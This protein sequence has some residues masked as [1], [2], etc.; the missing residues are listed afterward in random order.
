MSN[1]AEDI[2]ILQEAYK[3]TGDMNYKYQ[4][5]KLFDIFTEEKNIVANELRKIKI[6]KKGVKKMSLQ[7][8]DFQQAQVILNLVDFRQLFGFNVDLKELFILKE[9]AVYVDKV[10]NDCEYRLFIQSDKDNYRPSLNITNIYMLVNDCNYNKAIKDLMELYDIKVSDKVLAQTLTDE[11]IKYAKNIVAIRESIPKKYKNLYKLIK[12]YTMHFEHIQYISLESTVFKGCT[13][14]NQTIFPL[15]CRRFERDLTKLEKQNNIIVKNKS[16][17]TCSNVLA[18]LL[19]L[20]LIM[21]VDINN[22]TLQKFYATSKASDNH[23]NK[24]Y[25]TTKLLTPQVLEA[26]EKKA[27]RLLRNKI[28]ASTFN[29][30]TLSVIDKKNADKIFYNTVNTAKNK[31]YKAECEFG[32]S[33]DIQTIPNID[34]SLLPF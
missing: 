33:L 6:N 7:V 19:Y 32:N 13:Y 34:L 8:N 3:A 1:I 28:T 30:K 2:R 15:T 26:A 22:K 20:G 12:N 17:R 11:E 25:Y 18:L 23:Y 24:K 5:T 29:Y 31:E 27:T 16:F 21:E 4:I 9:V 14:R 10:N